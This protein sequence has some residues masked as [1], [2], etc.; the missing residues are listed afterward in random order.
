MALY[1]L[2]T[3]I[4]TLAFHAHPVV[5]V[6]IGQ[7]L[8]AGDQVALSIVTLR[9]IMEGRIQ[10]IARSTQPQKIIDAYHGLR[11]SAAFIASYAV[12]TFTPASLARF[13]TLLKLKLNVAKDDLRTAAIALDAGAIV[14]TR[15]FRDFRRVPGLVCEDWSV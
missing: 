4:A 15:N 9:E 13:D 12:Q 5:L 6:R 7:A 14:V 8:L 3:D 2:D 11:K 1:I 10:E